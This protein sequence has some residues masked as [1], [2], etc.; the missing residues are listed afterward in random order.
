MKNAVSA[1]I[2]PRSN[3]KNRR[4]GGTHRLHHQD[5]KK[6]NV[7]FLRSMRLLLVTANIFH[8]SPI[9]LTQMLEALGSSKHRFLQ[10]PQ[11]V[12]SQKTAFNLFRILEFLGS[13]LDTDTSHFMVF[14]GLLSPISQIWDVTQ[15]WAN[16]PFFSPFRF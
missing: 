2:M 14:H 3:C 12:I 6:Y 5:D 13:N 4:F 10:E 8:S 16:F 7:V 11:G 1:D 15:N 9:L